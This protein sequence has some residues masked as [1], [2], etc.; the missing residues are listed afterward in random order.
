MGIDQF[1]PAR[2]FR[3]LPAAP[4]YGIA[5]AVLIHKTPIRGMSIQRHRHFTSRSALTC[6]LRHRTTILHE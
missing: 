6:V 1:G 2:T 5:I 3:Q 4:A